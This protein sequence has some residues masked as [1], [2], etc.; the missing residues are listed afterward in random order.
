MWMLNSLL[1][2]SYATAQPFMGRMVSYAN[3]WGA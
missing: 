3:W 2:T 1:G